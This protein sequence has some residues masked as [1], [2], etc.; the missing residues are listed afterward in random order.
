[1]CEAEL[2]IKLDGCFILRVDDDREYSDRSARIESAPD[3]VSKQQA[4]DSL[5]A[6]A[7]VAGEAPDQSRRHCTV[8]RQ[9]PGDL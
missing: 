2:A 9:L 4:A 3:S 8:A 1:L 6:H 5:R 7:F